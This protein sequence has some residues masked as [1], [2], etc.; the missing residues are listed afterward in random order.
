LTDRCR[1]DWST[2]SAAISSFSPVMNSRTGTSSPRTALSEV[3]R[4][5]VTDTPGISVGYCMARN[6]PRRA[7]SSGLSSFSSVPSH[8]IV[9][10]VIS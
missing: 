10:P 8:V 7:R 5:F 4:K 2:S 3:R 6:T 9:P 1:N